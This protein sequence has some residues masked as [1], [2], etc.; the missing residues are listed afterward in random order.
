MIQKEIMDNRNRNN[1]YIHKFMSD[2]RE[3][4]YS[5]RMKNLDVRE[6][7]CRNGGKRETISTIIAVYTIKVSQMTSTTDKLITR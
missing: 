5:L 3:R 4:K 2:E 1:D 6:G 7:E